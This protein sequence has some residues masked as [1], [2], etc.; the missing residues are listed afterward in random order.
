MKKIL[1]LV[2]AVVFVMIIPMSVC[3]S[4]NGISFDEER[5]EVEPIAGEGLICNDKAIGNDSIMTLAFS[6]IT[7]VFEK[8]SNTKAFAE[9]MAVSGEKG[10]TSTAQ[11][12]R[13][14]SSTGKYANVSGAVA[15]KTVTM[16]TIHHVPEFSISASYK[17]RVKVTLDDG[18]VARIKYANLK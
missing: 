5:F 17:Y 3:A 12:Q 2:L 15:K 10:I 4:D 7:V 6:S 1:V 11:L 18:D 14:N 13:Y 8:T 9:I 16:N